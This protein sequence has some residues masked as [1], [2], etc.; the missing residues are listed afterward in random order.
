[1]VDL[2]VNGVFDTLDEAKRE[3][4]ALICA[5]RTDG[6]GIT[7]DVDGNFYDFAGNQ[8]ESRAVLARFTVDVVRR[9]NCD[10][11]HGAIN[12]GYAAEEWWVHRALQD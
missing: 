7:F 12:W 6:F 8:I 5:L 4:Y 10:S 2:K 11:Y 1:M 9:I 3:M